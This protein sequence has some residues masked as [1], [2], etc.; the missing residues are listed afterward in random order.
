VYTTFY[1]FESSGFK[2]M[3][4]SSFRFSHYGYN[5]AFDSIVDAMKRREGFV[6]LTGAPGI[7][8]TMLVDDLAARFESDGF[9][10]GKVTSSLVDADDLPRLVAFAFGMQADICSNARTL[11]KLKEQLI[12]KNS[13]TQ[14][15]ILLIDEAQVLSAD[16]LQELY[17]LFDLI[18]RRGYIVQIL[19]AGQEPLWERLRQPECTQIQQSIVERCRLLPLSANET[20][21]YVAQAL[22]KI[23]WRGD[24]EIS[25]D[26]LCLIYE[27]TGGVPRL[28]NLT[29]GRLLLHGSL[30]ELHALGLHDVES[31]LE[32]MGEDHPELLLSEHEP[33]RPSQPAHSEPLLPLD[34]R[35][36]DDS[37]SQHLPVQERLL[38]PVTGR[39]PNATAE[40]VIDWR[41]RVN[42][43][44]WKWALAGLS[45]TIIALYLIVAIGFQADVSAP[46]VTSDPKSREQ[47]NIAGTVR[48]SQSA[49]EQVDAPLGP[50]AH[51]VPSKPD[52]EVVDL[53]N[54]D[55]KADDLELSIVWDNSAIN[56]FELTPKTHQI[57]LADKLPAPISAEIEGTTSL[58]AGQ[59]AGEEQQDQAA[60]E[61]SELLA[62][63]ELAFAKNRL[64]VPSGDNAYAYYQA[65]LTRDPVNAD[66]RTGVRRIVQ[67]YRQLAKQRLNRS[68]LRGAGVF[69][70]RGL[71]IW[72]RDRQ[73]LAIKRKASKP[74]VTR[75]KD[76][77]P[78]MLERIQ[79]WFLSGDTNHSAFLDQ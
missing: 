20:R 47:S 29:M 14:P 12:A 50:T 70:S 77:L 6:V 41:Q 56:R 51:M 22:R 43:E 48:P 44:N 61:T 62:K 49:A 32:Q 67:R 23:G 3:P 24:P 38:L 17:L 7:G 31:V 52:R 46:S 21:A 25:A 53:G 74:R 1:G 55:E 35:A 60:H 79:E 78:E 27:R 19:L 10:V 15:V 4:D 59:G 66:A 39:A 13:S 64:T 26:A 9:T 11:T 58:S 8:K 72:P 42:G 71:K 65:V 73:L 34:E 36:V 16:A 68:D 18:A 45:V 37:K 2:M 75:Q 5:D 63:A 54:G 76:E 30:G 40:T 33:Q 28:V 69:A 57:L